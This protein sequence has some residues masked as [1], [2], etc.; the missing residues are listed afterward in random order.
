MNQA[1]K[2]V[3]FYVDNSFSMGIEK[4][5]LSMLDVAKGKAARK[6]LPAATIMIK[7]KYSPTILLLMKVNF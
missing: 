4:N 2:A 1:P 3:S 7:Y 5:A 6:S